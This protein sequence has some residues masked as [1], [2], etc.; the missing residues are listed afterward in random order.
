MALSRRLL[1]T[2]VLLLSFVVI[3]A[4]QASAADCATFVADLNYPDGSPV[5]PGQ[6]ITKGWRL[7]NCGATNW[8]NY[9]AVRVGGSYGPVSFDVPSVAAGATGDL[10]TSITVPSTSGTH[11]ATYQMKGPSGEFGDVFWVEV[12]VNAPTS[13]CAAFVA[14]LTYPDGS[15][16]DPGQTISKGW[17]LRNCGTTSWSGYR[18]VRVDGSYGPASFAVPGVA[19]DT[20][21]DLYTSIT[22]PSTAGLHRA[23]YRM[24]G[25]SGQFGDAFWVEVN[26]GSTSSCAEFV[27]HI[28]YPDGTEVAPG[29]RINKGWRLRNCGSLAWSADHRAVRVSG[30][31]GPAWFGLPVVDPGDTGDIWADITVPTTPGL[32]RATYRLENASGQFGDLF[33]V[34]VNVV[35]PTSDCATF[36]GHENYADGSP[37][38][39]GL[40]INKGWWLHNCGANSWSGGYRAVRVSGDFGP[41]S[42]DIPVVTAGA[43][44][45]L[46]ADITVPTLPGLYRAEYRLEGPNGQFGDLFWVELRARRS[47]PSADCARFVGHL[48]YPDGSP[49]SPGQTI[50]KGWLLE[51]C[52]GTAWNPVQIRAVRVLGSFG[53]PAF[54]FPATYVGET[55]ELHAD[56]R[57]P[58]TPGLHRATYQLKDRRKGLFG[59][60]FWV[61]V[62]VVAPTAVL[63]PVFRGQTLTVL[64]GY[65]DP[66]PGEA[67]NI[68]GGGADHC[69]NQKYGLDLVPSV[70][71]TGML[72]AQS[73]ERTSAAPGDERIL[74][75]LPGRI[76]WISGDC[77]GIRTRDD[78]NLNVC[79]FARFA[80]AL[81][82]EVARGAVLGTRSTSWIHLSLDDR[83]RDL[84]MPPVPFTGAHKLEGLSLEPGPDDQRNQ[85]AGVSFSSTN[86]AGFQV[87]AGED[88]SGAEGTLVS[89]SGSFSAPDLSLA[90]DVEWDFGDGSTEAGTLTPTHAYA[91]DGIYNV[92]LKV[93][94]SDGVVASDALEVTVTNVSPVV[95][96]GDDQ[97]G[98][99]AQPLRFEG[100]F[101]DPGSAD[102]HNYLWDFGD[103]TTA[104]TLA[105]VHRYRDAGTYQVTLTVRDD[106]GG[107]GSDSLAVTISDEHFCRAA[108]VE[109]F[110]AYGKG[111]DPSGWVD[112]ELEGRR[113]EKEEAFRTRLR[114]G[115]IVYVNHEERGVSEYQGGTA[116]AWR[117]YEWSGQFRLPEG[118][119]GN[120][121][122][123]YSDIRSGR[124]YQL[125]ATGSD[126]R[127]YSLLKGLDRSLTGVTESG[128]VPEGKV[129]YRF[130]IRV[131]SLAGA[132]AIHA[133]FWREEDPEPTDWMIDAL[134][135]DEPLVSGS[136]GIMA[137]AEE[138]VFD[139]FRVEALSPDSGIPGDR[140]GDEV[141]DDADNCPATPNP[142]Q[143]DVDSDGTGNVCDA[144]TAAFGG[145]DACLDSVYDPK[146]GLS[147]RVTALIGQTRHVSGEG[148]CGARGFYRLPEEGGL[149]FQTPS[150][151]E[152]GRYRFR[153]RLRT[154]ERADEQVPLLMKIRGRSYKVPFESDE[155]HR[156]WRT[157]K[158]VSV[159]LPPGVHAVRLIA[160]EGSVDVEEVELEEACAEESKAP[161]GEKE[162]DAR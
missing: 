152:E 128:F 149:V 160:N 34:E 138:S 68:G 3:P 121:F 59:Q 12:N 77:L 4:G 112:Y 7:R 33:H 17:R 122:L 24:Q 142:E 82:D 156:E 72:A 23:T 98:M 153:F 13:D 132:T 25:P 116:L 93:T 66:L 107:E 20:T 113:F 31:F 83:Y 44:G 131:E 65:N 54:G 133:R 115:E 123:F 162:D 125:K 117:D 97:A 139:D 147:S 56:V 136:I 78:L 108:F 161:P 36:M 32:H 158:A 127:G 88:R 102:T 109:T 143:A 35:V 49:V 126:H 38:R 99:R 64:N 47:G 75:P 58:T 50:S 53:P 63:A 21:G 16:V 18:A 80:V 129:K 62:N 8:V 85:H 145:E 155:E 15:Q 114:D 141:C 67:C 22:V 91:D 87:L 27:E 57:V 84:S 70:Q 5:D 100:A 94:R 89:F 52:G 130:R 76:A 157:S 105:A 61:E 144:C 74:A 95:E 90:H 73:S 103:G 124:F 1:I 150:L 119:R 42:F 148:K 2:V 146:T 137:F 46:H 40:T 41:V 135:G 10:Y 79:H 96:A 45:A 111:A 120:A 71:A 101:A 154:W 37:V 55:A 86:V 81:D 106:D 28:R 39:P 9:R 140:D 26:V 69:A 151:P 159:T 6:T 92:T 48:N 104:D 134:D 118:K 19:P 29:E 11:R 51:N 60:V 14:D 30:S 110:D 43:T